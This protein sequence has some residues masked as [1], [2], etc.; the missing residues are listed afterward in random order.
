MNEQSLNFLGRF[1]C[2]KKK[3]CITE[4]SVAS[5][6]EQ[7]VMNRFDTSMTLIPS[8]AFPNQPKGRLRHPV[9]SAL[10]SQPLI[11]PWL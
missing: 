1:S 11:R 3:K 6:G 10:P 8:K 4:L 7:R 9:S 2:L 5:K